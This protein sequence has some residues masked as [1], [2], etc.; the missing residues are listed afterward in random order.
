MFP[1]DPQEQRAIVEARRIGQGSSAR[2]WPV[3]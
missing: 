3:P 2:F 1:P